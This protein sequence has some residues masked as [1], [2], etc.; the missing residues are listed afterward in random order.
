ME[1]TPNDQY[2]SNKSFVHDMMNSIKCHRLFSHKAISSLRQGSFDKPSLVKMHL[3][4]LM[5]TKQFTDVILMAQFLTREI[6][7]RHDICHMPARFLITLNLLDE[8]GFQPGNREYL[9]TPKHSHFL[10]F[11]QV[12]DQLGVDRATRNDYVYGEAAI[13]LRDFVE[14]HMD[15]FLAL[16]LYLAVTEEEAIIFSPPMREAARRAGVPVDGGYYNA[17]GSSSDD[18]T[19]AED[20][21]HQND[22]LVILSQYL[23]AEDY[24]R[25]RELSQKFCDM[26]CAFWDEQITHLER[27][28]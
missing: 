8:L 10:L 21:E 11:D 2:K 14:E 26:W 27:A 5:L 25:T 19:E 6:D 23:I 24:P 12:I 18:D 7:K 16:L 9:G 4:F 13:A 22:V 20:D 1:S 3:D 15:N 17:H 28:A